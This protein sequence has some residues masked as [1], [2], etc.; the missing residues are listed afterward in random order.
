[1]NNQTGYFLIFLAIA[2]FGILFWWLRDMKKDKLS[3]ENQQFN[4][5]QKNQHLNDVS[6]SIFEE[7]KKLNPKDIG[8]YETTESNIKK[9]HNNAKLSRDNHMHVGDEDFRLPNLRKE[10]NSTYR[11]LEEGE[12]AL[13]DEM[14]QR[15]A[16][17]YENTSFS[18]LIPAATGFTESGKMTIPFSTF[19]YLSSEMKPVI[20]PNGDVKIV[21]L[22]SLEESINI[23]LEAGTPFLVKD[24]KLKLV[25]KYTKEDAERLIHNFDS[26]LS[27]MLDEEKEKSEQRLEKINDLEKSIEKKYAPASKELDKLK[28]AHDKL[29]VE[30]SSNKSD[31]LS[32]LELVSEFTI[33]NAQKDLEIN[34]LN[35]LISGRMEL[36]DTGSVDSNKTLEVKSLDVQHD[37]NKETD[38]NNTVSEEI[39]SGAIPDEKSAIV[40]NK[41]KSDKGSNTVKESALPIKTCVRKD[42]FDF[43][44]LAILKAFASEREKE[45]VDTIGLITIKAGQT[46][47]ERVLVCNINNFFK[48]FDSW[49][50]GMDCN[51][52]DFKFKIKEKYISVA[53]EDFI[54]FGKVLLLTL[55][56]SEINMADWA[57]VFSE[58]ELN[59][60]SNSKSIRLAR[61]QKE[62]EIKYLPNFERKA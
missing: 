36:D 26:E 1:M 18:W 15:I 17:S 5:E 14:L 6:A 21:N 52:K 28:K 55:A 48:F 25:K 44:E 46:A 8:R 56:P 27:K 34:R 16:D 31:A 3:S 19:A 45:L 24:P 57:E 22:L 58:A 11:N 10:F 32:A 20:Q 54:Q 49:A 43:I 42:F 30:N 61:M 9:F 4:G 40:L 13:S 35:D 29:V 33:S 59:S 51:K 7:E 50:L 38:E 23:C 60:A 12:V 37:D 47:E 53:G 39:K 41:V 2:F 62:R